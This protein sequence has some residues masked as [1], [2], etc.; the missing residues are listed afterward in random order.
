MCCTT[1]QH[2]H[3]FTKVWL[4]KCVPLH[5]LKVS[6]N[7]S[8]CHQ[9]AHFCILATP[10]TT[11]VQ[12]IQLPIPAFFFLLYCISK[13]RLKQLFCWTH[14]KSML[15]FHLC[16]VLYQTSYNSLYFLLYWRKQQI[17]QL[18][19]FTAGTLMPKDENIV[20]KC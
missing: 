5:I 16:L 15:I 2:I 20:C 7:V 3:C 19:V 13:W 14:L 18:C 17:I 9:S 11:H 12:S 10:W 4:Y 8:S 1:M 6:I